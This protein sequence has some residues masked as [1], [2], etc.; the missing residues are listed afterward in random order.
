MEK[1]ECQTM[2]FG[3]NLQPVLCG[4]NWLIDL[5]A[6]HGGFQSPPFLA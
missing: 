6:V 5:L 3:L 2:G 1:R 4:F